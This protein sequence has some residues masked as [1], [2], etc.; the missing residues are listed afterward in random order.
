MNEQTTQITFECPHCHGL[1]EMPVPAEA[2]QEMGC[3][4]CGA[5]L[6]SHEASSRKLSAKTVA[7]LIGALVLAA[8]VG[9]FVA[10]TLKKGKKTAEVPAV[11]VV[12]APREASLATNEFTV[13]GLKVENQGSLRY[14]RG[15]IRNDRAEQRFGVRI[16]LEL[17]DTNDS[18]VGAASDYRATV[19]SNE[20]WQFRALVVEPRAVSA[21]LG[22]I[23]E[24]R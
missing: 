11:P 10:I 15:T 12:E 2:P 13:T 20:V 22:S 19:Q 6:P 3:P 7:M 21:T 24:E 23:E 14:V 18:R 9:L 1:V 4:H 5:L 8:A 16:R 17:L